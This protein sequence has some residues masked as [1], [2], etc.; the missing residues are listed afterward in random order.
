MVGRWLSDQNLPMIGMQAT[1]DHLRRRRTS[2]E[3]ELLAY[4]DGRGRW[5]DVRSSDIN[6]YLQEHL[7]TE[8]T[9]KDFRTWAATVLAAVGLA[10][11]EAGDSDTARRRAVEELGTPEG[12]ERAARERYGMVEPGEEVYIIPQE[13]R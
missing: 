10:D 12:L 7:G 5:V 11:V 1:E 9:A 13:E 6:E 8:F 2:A 3:T 4:K